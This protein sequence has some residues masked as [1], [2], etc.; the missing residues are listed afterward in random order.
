MSAKKQKE[1]GETKEPGNSRE[2]A[3]TKASREK[4]QIRLSQISQVDKYRFRQIDIQMKDERIK[5]QKSEKKKRTAVPA[6]PFLFQSAYGSFMPV[7][8]RDDLEWY[9]FVNSRNYCFRR[10]SRGEG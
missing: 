5:N 1:S 6:V 10:S 8:I 3:D 4:K 9:A 7:R 2:S